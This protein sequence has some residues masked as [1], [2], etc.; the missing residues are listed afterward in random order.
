MKV[1]EERVLADRRLMKS[2]GQVG[3]LLAACSEETLD[4]G[5]YDF[6]EKPIDLGLV[7][8]GDRFYVRRCRLARHQVA[9]YRPTGCGKSA[10]QGP[11]EPRGEIP[12]GH[13]D[14]RDAALTRPV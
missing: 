14:A 6:G 12:W 9:P 8:Q 7:L 10:R 11:R 2:G 1:R 3:E 5:P 13:P 4:A